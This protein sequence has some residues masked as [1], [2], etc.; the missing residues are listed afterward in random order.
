MALLTTLERAPIGVIRARRREDLVALIRENALVAGSEGA[1]IDPDRVLKFI[2]SVHESM[3]SSMQRDD[4]A[5]RPL[6]LDALGGAI[7]RRAEKHGV[8]IPVTRRIVGELRSR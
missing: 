4:A 3:E 6:E 1:V 7:I 5:G 2:D 8:E